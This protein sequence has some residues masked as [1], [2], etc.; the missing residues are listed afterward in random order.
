MIFFNI[1]LIVYAVVLIGLSVYVARGLFRGAPSA[2]SSS[3]PPIRPPFIETFTG[4]R[5][6]PLAPVVDAI[7]IEDI[8]HSL[9]NQCRFSGHVR[10]FYSVAEHS[11]RV[12]RLLEDLGESIEV[13]LWGLLHDA[14]EAY[15]VDLPTPLKSDEQI[16]RG[17]R[18]AERTLMAAVCQR[19]DLDPIEPEAVRY[20]DAVMLATEVR[21]LM[22]GRPDHWSG[23][24]HRPD[25]ENIHPWG[26]TFSEGIF[27]SRFEQLTKQLNNEKEAA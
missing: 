16:G 17:Y 24:T 25:V 2:P 1:A 22:F 5:F 3:T 19:F 21:D 7:A 6:R 9:S 15:L 23:L 26:S 12:S 10:Q 20:A 14:S 11:V 4:R 18:S 8:A 13:Q 27:L